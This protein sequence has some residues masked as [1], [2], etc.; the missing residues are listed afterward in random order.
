[1][2]INVTVNNGQTGL[3]AH[4]VGRYYYIILRYA[5]EERERERERDTQSTKPQKGGRET[6]GPHTTEDQP[7]AKSTTHRTPR[8]GKKRTN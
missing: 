8:T 6:R 2:F 1:M 7:G 3:Y 4:V 5:E